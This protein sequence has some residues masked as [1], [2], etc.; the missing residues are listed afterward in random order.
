MRRQERLDDSEESLRIAME[1]AQAKVWTAIPAIVQSVDFVAQTITAQ[2][3]IQGAV[4]SPDGSVAQVNLPLL[5]DVPIMYPR[6]GGFA[7]TFP[8]AAGD[9]VL[10]VFASRCID[11]WW[12][13]GGVG[14]QAEVRMHDLSDGFALLAPTSQPKVLPAVSAQNVQLR[15]EVGTT[16]LEITPDGKIKLVAVTEIDADA[17]TI[18]VTGATVVNVAAPEINLDGSSI[19]NIAAPNITLAGNIST[20]GSGGGGGT[21]EISGDLIHTDGSIT[22]LGKT[23]DGTHTHGGVQAGG[24]NTQPPN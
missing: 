7:L 6:A 3:A 17:P 24:D 12:Q 23:I 22:S 8:I 21:F 11:S 15:D 18:N 20:G 13:N 16:Y 2:P 9:E 1:S 10:V 4:Q 14:A 19:V 5:V